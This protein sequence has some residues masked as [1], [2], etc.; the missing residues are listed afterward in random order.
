MENGTLRGSAMYTVDGHYLDVSIRDHHAHRLCPLSLPS[1][2]SH[3]SN[4]TAAGLLL[5]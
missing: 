3:N 1:P 4:W 2:W 5:M